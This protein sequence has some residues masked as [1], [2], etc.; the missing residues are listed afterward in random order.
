MN[1]HKV[2]EWF[3]RRRRDLEEKQEQARQRARAA[4][5]ATRPPASKPKPLSSGGDASV[6]SAFANFGQ[7]LT[8]QAPK[9]PEEPKLTQASKN[10]FKLTFMTI[11]YFLSFSLCSS[12]NTIISFNLQTL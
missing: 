12:F 4:A 2:K 3:N 9:V 1:E 10:S 8:P 6:F 5:A 7:Y 11:T